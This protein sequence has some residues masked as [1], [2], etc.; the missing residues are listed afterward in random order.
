MPKTEFNYLDDRNWDGI[1]Q[2][3]VLPC[4]AK[5]ISPEDIP[6]VESFYFDD[7]STVA[8][9]QTFSFFWFIFLILK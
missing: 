6:Y 9:K 3:V 8:G 1:I 7:P 5:G 2:F 4:N